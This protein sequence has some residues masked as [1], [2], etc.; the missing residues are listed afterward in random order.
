MGQSLYI[1]VIITSDGKEF[2][3]SLK[4]YSKDS[5]TGEFLSNEISQVLEEVGVS[6]FCAVVSDHAT[7]VALAKKL[8]AEK[9]PSILP[10][11]CITHYINLLSNDIIK[12]S[13]VENIINE[14]KEVINYFKRSHTAN[15][16][17]QE[18][19]LNNMI[20]G[21]G[22]KKHVKTRWITAFDCT[23]SIIRCESAIKN[24]SYNII[25]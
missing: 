6:K 20:K 9:Y 4:N 5:H 17:I 16:F 7:N 14:C 18:E 23:D 13:W 3:H 8:I 11:R 24:V 1:F 15:A 12:L 21:D 25:I 22:L 10:M 19:I 2:V